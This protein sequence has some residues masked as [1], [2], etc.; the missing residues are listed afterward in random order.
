VDC[1]ASSS[2]TKSSAGR[3]ISD[4]A[5]PRDRGKAKFLVLGSAPLNFY[6]RA[7]QSLAGRIAHVNVDASR[8]TKWTGLGPIGSGARWI[9][10]ELPGQSESL[11][12]TWRL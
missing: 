3:A 10:A 4:A 12:M 7:P 8:S 6:G 9:P 5:R 2:S 11:S 1:E